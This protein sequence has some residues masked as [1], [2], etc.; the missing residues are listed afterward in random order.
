MNVAAFALGAVVK[1]LMQIVGTRA[2]SSS[3]LQQQ[4]KFTK[5]AT[6]K[7]VHLEL[8]LN[9]DRGPV[10]PFT[11]VPPHS[12][13]NLNP[14]FEPMQ[15]SNAASSTTLSSS[16]AAELLSSSI[17]I[18][19]SSAYLLLR[20]DKDCCRSCLEHRELNMYYW[21]SVGGSHSHSHS[22]MQQTAIVL[23]QEFSARGFWA[24][25]KTRCR[26]FGRRLGWNISRRHR[27]FRFQLSSELWTNHK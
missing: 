14:I 17:S 15:C 12:L 1:L 9:F 23:W 19:C 27:G 5:Q 25:F 7:K 18:C 4:Q 2:G 22:S 20:L 10:V 8:Q 24:L 11:A 13:A 3:A 21:L 26:C 16:G 6:G